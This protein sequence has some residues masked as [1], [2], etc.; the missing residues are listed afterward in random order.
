M[1]ARPAKKPQAENDTKGS[2]VTRQRRQ[3]P[4]KGAKTGGE[5][6]EPPAPAD[7]VDEA[8]WESFPASDS[9]AY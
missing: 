7:P 4:E 8:S 9:P 2:K 1:C 3:G 5:N 6:P